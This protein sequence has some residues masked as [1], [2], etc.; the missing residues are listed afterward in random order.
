MF[1]ISRTNNKNN[2][3]IRILTETHKKL[4]LD[5]FNIKICDIQKS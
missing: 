4:E 2:F 3:L 1:K 5:I